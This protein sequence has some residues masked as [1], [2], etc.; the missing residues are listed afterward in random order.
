M[1]TYIFFYIIMYF[2]KCCYIIFCKYNIYIHV[3]PL[4]KE[5]HYVRCFLYATNLCEYYHIFNFDSMH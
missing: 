1:F 5:V 2:L 4:K 3:H